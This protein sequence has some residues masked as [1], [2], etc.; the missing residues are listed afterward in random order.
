MFATF[1]RLHRFIVFSMVANIDNGEGR[2]LVLS[3]L[4]SL[5]ATWVQFSLRRMCEFAYMLPIK[6]ER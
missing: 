4:F 3:V 1:S 6:G 2:M 5:V